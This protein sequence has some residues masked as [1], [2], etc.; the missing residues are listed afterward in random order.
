MARILF[1]TQTANPL[2]GVEVWLEDLVA[3]LAQK[4][5]VTLG[6]VRGRRFHDP[7]RYL[8]ARRIAVPSFEVDGRTGTTEGRVRAVFDAIERADADLVVPVN[9]ADTLEAVRRHKA[10][11]RDIRMLYPLHGIGGEYLLDIDEFRG[12]ID[13]V[14]V[15]NRLAERAVRE[16]AQIPQDRMGYVLY[17]AQ[18][19]LETPSFAPSNRFVHAGRLQET[20]K[21]IGDLIPLSRTLAER[22]VEF[23]L[24]IAGSGPEESRLRE[25]LAS[26]PHVRFLGALSREALYERVY[27]GAAALLLFS[28]WETGPIVAWEAMRHGATIITSDYAGRKSEGRLLDGENALIAPVGDIDA[29]AS[30]VER[31]VREPE[32]QVRLRR[33]A[34]ETAEGEVRIDQ[35]LAGWTAA[36]ERCLT[37]EP[38]RDT[39]EVRI[40]TSRGRL[41][42]IAGRHAESIRRAFGIGM[43]HNDPGAEWPHSNHTGDPRSARLDRE[44]LA[45]E[46]RRL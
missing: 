45:L 21:R 42:R 12:V 2:G 36:F 15:T 46:T 25:A 31:I 37:I 28:D 11:G 13:L 30:A 8:A 19:P 38:A 18:P 7:Q 41:D 1:V 14:V 24:D 26:Q 44:V 22:G 33:A 34:Y 4:H 43:T 9:I 3:A 27:P 35:S 20:Q 23:R 16:L 32:L 5:D 40:P 10:Q 39:H 29:L 17:G 6:L